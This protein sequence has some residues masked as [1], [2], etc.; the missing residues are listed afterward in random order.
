MPTFVP[1]HSYAAQLRRTFMIAAALIAVLWFAGLDT[2]ALFMPDEGRYAEIP[3]EMLVSGDWITPR[4]DDLKYFEKPPLQ[5]WATAAGFALFG[6]HG[7]SA[8]LWPALTGMLGVLLLVFA[9]NRLGPPGAGPLAGIAAASSWGYVLASQYLTLDMGLTFFMTLTLVA[10]LLA[11]HDPGDE[12]ARR[13]WMLVAWTAMALAML[14]K[15]LEGIV[16]PGLVLGAYA[17]V[18]RDWG[19]LRRMHWRAGL[20]TFGIIALPW[21]VLVQ[22]R[23]PEFFHFFF[24]YEHF[25][26]YLEPGHDR[27]GPWWYYVPILLL[28]M[29]PWSPALVGALAR[30]TKRSAPASVLD[31]DRLLLLWGAVIL[32]FFSAS[33]SKLPAYIVP[34]MP[35]LALLV[36]RD[37]ARRTTLALRW[38]APWTAL[39]GLGAL[40]LAWR[41]PS[42]ARVPDVAGPLAGYVPWLVAAGAL[43]LLGA[44]LAWGCARRDWDAALLALALCSLGGV[45]IA[46]WGLHGFDDY[47]SARGLVRRLG[48]DHRRFAPRAPFYSVDTFDQSLPF[49][50]GRPVTLVAFRSELELGTAMEPAKYVASLP[51]F[52]RRWRTGGEA[53]AV[54]TP[55]MYAKLARSGLP[56][57]LLAQDGRRV[58]IARTD[59]RPEL[60]P[61]REGLL[62]SLLGRIIH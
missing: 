51:Q 4:L 47:Y 53:Y 50:L 18:Q 28:G 22:L 1:A 58:V 8:R 10:F 31:V 54:M 38:I 42:L 27:P 57:R 14:T 12:R 41:L 36:A 29:L 39:A 23:N 46:L 26:R 56:M 21:F 32:V 11:H 49:Y 7:W 59:Q 48:A 19:L 44:A 24:I 35:A 34:V 3:R 37:A 16:L 20:L 61:R 43:W 13:R 60:G 6:E 2:R 15:G 5:Y 52:E 9:G 25:D 45:Q 40:A 17:V 62:P 55:Q 30:A 33:Q